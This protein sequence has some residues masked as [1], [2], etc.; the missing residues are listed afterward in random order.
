MPPS[1]AAQTPRRNNGWN[2]NV[3]HVPKL[4]GGQDRRR[5]TFIVIA[6]PD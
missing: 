3:A 6:R 2:L 1:G 4:R 5:R